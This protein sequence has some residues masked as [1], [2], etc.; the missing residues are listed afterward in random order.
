MGKVIFAA[1]RLPL[2][3][4]DDGDDV[5]I[6]PCEPNILTAAVESL[7]EQGKEV[8]WVGAHS[9]SPSEPQ[10]SKI[11]AKLLDSKY[12][13]IFIDADTARDHFNGFC[14]S[15]VWP[16]FHYYGAGTSSYTTDS[17]RAYK[18]VNELFSQEIVNIYEEGD[19]ILIQDYH[20]MLLPEML[21]VAVPTCKI[22]F[23]LHVPWPTSE[24]Y[25][26]LP[27]RDH[28]LRGLLGADVIGFQT[29]PYARHFLSA[30]TRI[31]GL[32]ATEQ[33]VEIGG[34]HYVRVEV[35]PVG[36]DSMRFQTALDSPEVQ[37]KIQELTETFA[38]KK[39]VV[40]RDPLEYIQGIPH[41]LK[42]FD[43]FLAAYPEWRGKVVLYQECVPNTETL[44]E[45]SYTQ[46]CEEVEKLVGSINGK[47][48]T[49]EY[50]PIFY[51]NRRLKWEDLCGLLAIADVGL[52]TALRDG[53]NITAF[54]FIACQ[55]KKQS[56]LVLS[57]FAGSA[58]CLSGA[59]LVNPWDQ[60]KC[61][62]TLCDA[63]NMPENHKTIRYSHNRDYVF[64]HNAPFWITS[65]LKI[66]ENNTRQQTARDTIA[67]VNIRDLISAYKKSNKR[68]ILLDYD[69]TLTP[70]V[71]MP[72][73]A[74][75]TEEVLSLLS[76][77]A[78]NQKNVTYVITGRERRIMDEWLGGITA[79]LSCEHGSFFRPFVMND[80][81]VWKDCTSE[82][83]LSWKPAIK[84]IFDDYTE[85]TPGSFVE[86]KEIGISW[87]YRNADPEFAEYQKKDLIQHLL[88]LP[89][90]P[91]DI[92]P[93]KKVVEVRPQGISKGSVVRRIL[94]QE[95]EVDFVLAIGDD[96]T[97]EEMFEEVNK[98]D[99]I[100]NKFSI[101][102]EKKPSV[103]AYY[104]DNQ[105]HVVDLLSKLAYA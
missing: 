7:K 65:L 91:I 99:T 74:V 93:G 97:D 78:Q 100:K 16:L 64:T 63:L 43:A 39:I 79:G 9:T 86:N 82:L 49:L 96:K 98:K 31:L 26:S 41:K 18:L 60:K 70:I 92:L 14:K 57:E 48:S 3:V 20:L 2:S 52:V 13:P 45:K 8:V 95:P 17:W 22:S 69:G 83:D 66:L 87:H 58:N 24:L 42:M 67:R 53:M 46:L 32:T 51:L 75:P 94:S 90:L 28:V 105:R 71:K 68:L 35:E 88:D 10:K 5:K 89:N 23:F 72:S 47:Y 11:R 77:L 27:V 73:M 76:T 44:S 19:Q 84:G 59:M 103:A 40:A 6:T 101:T 1:Y 30:V 12:C 4:E 15:V 56:P 62:E 25:R 54:E 81:S 21:R 33:G 34:G 38:G 55:Q 29:F 85:R 80:V 61:I 102:V 50:S 36:I 37:L 104:T